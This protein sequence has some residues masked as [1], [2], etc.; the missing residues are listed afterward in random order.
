M[1]HRAEFRVPRSS[2][3]RVEYVCKRIDSCPFRL[4]AS[5]R[6][7]TW[8]VHKFDAEHTCN[9]DLGSI[10]ARNVRAQ[11]V[12]AYFARKMRRQGSIM[13]PRDIMAEL[14]Q[15]FGIRASY[16]VAFR[17]RNAAISIIYGGHG[18]SFQMLPSYFEVLRQHNPD[19]VT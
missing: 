13:K 3:S 8:Y 18:E 16:S 12:T 17:A 2:T 9:R 1:E 19:T 11:A 5:W 15:V 6:S 4:R 10:G 14:L 7:G